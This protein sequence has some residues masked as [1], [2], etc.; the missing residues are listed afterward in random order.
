MVNVTVAARSRD[1]TRR[2]RRRKVAG[3]AGR[4][5]RVRRNGTP[6]GSTRDHAGFRSPEWLTVTAITTVFVRRSKRGTARFS[7]PVPG[8]ARM[9]GRKP[10]PCPERAD[11]RGA[12]PG[13]PG[14]AGAGRPEPAVRS[15]GVRPGRGAGRAP[16]AGCRL[17]VPAGGRERRRHPGGRRPARVRPALPRAV[18]ILVDRVHGA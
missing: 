15:A 7:I 13:A 4:V 10:V 11:G 12:G 17:D 2:A 14:E 3:L 8:P 1:S 6:A 18:G 16:A 5:S 9:P